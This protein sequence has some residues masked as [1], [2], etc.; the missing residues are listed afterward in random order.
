VPFPP[1]AQT[2]RA[3]GQS[4]T[5]RVESKTAPRRHAAALSRRANNA[6]A[7][8]SFTG[9]TGGKGDAKRATPRHYA[10]VPRC[11]NKA[12]KAH[13]CNTNDRFAHN[14]P[15]EPM[16][17]FH[18]V[19][20]PLPPRIQRIHP[21]PLGT[22]ISRLALIRSYPIL[23]NRVR[24]ELIGDCPPFSVRDP[25]TTPS[26]DFISNRAKRGFQ[27]HDVVVIR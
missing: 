10:D 17:S 14:I 6:V 12:S 23:S 11:R 22:P 18:K 16:L 7:R 26:G 27:H 19:A 20:W 25:E 8:T 5:L 21:L 15:P 9:K 1:K 13:I 24:P 4:N 2:A 3:P